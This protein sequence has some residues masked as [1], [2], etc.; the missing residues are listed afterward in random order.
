M[1][2]LACPV[3]HF[4]LSATPGRLG[5]PNQHHFDLSRW[6]HVHLSRGRIPSGD[7][8]AMV[9]ARLRFL[10]RGHFAPLADT[11][12]SIVACR[13]PT[14]IV[15][16]GAGPGYYLA[17]LVD[18]SPTSSG[19]AV[20]VSRHAARQAARVHP[21]IAS[22]VADHHRLPLRDDAID[23]VTCVFAPRDPSE[24]HRVLRTTG[25]CLVVTPS[26]SHLSELR[27]RY[28]GLAIEPNKRE[29]LLRTFAPWFELARTTQ[30]EL[31][32][33]LTPEDIADALAMGPA[34]FHP[35]RIAAPASESLQT[36]AAFAIFELVPRPVARAVR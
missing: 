26:P 15:D 1:R 18:R 11:L 28:G 6:G 23:L 34:A 19:I 3:C 22:V 12:A 25:R 29:R 30:L 24:L 17:S 31:S 8:A 32:L 20:D 36:T 27:G 21:R 4:P 33:C 14:Y 9:Q 16:V 2:V 10:A 13:P 5:C 35:D 7:T